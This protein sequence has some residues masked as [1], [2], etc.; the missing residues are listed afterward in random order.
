MVGSPGQ[1]FV[2]CVIRRQ[3]HVRCQIYRLTLVNTRR[4]AHKLYLCQFDGVGNQV[5]RD[6]ERTLHRVEVGILGQ[7]TQ[8]GRY[9]AG[10]GTGTFVRDGQFAA[11]AVTLVFDFKEGT[12][13]AFDC[14]DDIV[15]Q[16]LCGIVHLYALLL[17]HLAVGKRNR[18]RGDSQAALDLLRLAGFLIEL[19]SATLSRLIRFE[20]V[21]IKFHRECLVRFG[22]ISYAVADRDTPTY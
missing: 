16:V 10:L 11:L 18:T 13:C 22:Y 15:R 21:G 12:V 14:P 20:A 7:I 3:L 5:E 4:S 1:R 9:G 17:A 6:R 2:G 19:T 8:L